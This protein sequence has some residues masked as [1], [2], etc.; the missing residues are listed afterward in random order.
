MPAGLIC[1]QNVGTF[2][3]SDGRQCTKAWNGGCANGKNKD[4]VRKTDK[5]Y[6]FEECYE[7][8]KSDENCDSFSVGTNKKRCIT[9]VAGCT[10]LDESLK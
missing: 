7:I 1:N 6:T 4:I 10:K 5:M 8:C 9:F 2:N 3:G